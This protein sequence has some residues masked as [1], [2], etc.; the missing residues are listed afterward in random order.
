M[1]MAMRYGPEKIYISREEEQDLY[2][3]MKEGDELARDDLIIGHKYLVFTTANEYANYGSYEDLVQEGFIGLIRAVDKYDLNRS[4]LRTYSLPAIRQQ[5]LRY[6]NKSRHIIRLPEPQT[7][8]LLKL[9]RAKSAIEEKLGREATTHELLNDPTVIENHK[10]FQKSYRSKLTIKEYI[11]LLEFSTSPQSLNAPVFDDSATSFED[12][13]ED[14]RQRSEIDRIDLE[15][16]LNH[17]MNMLTD[18]E[19]FILESI[20]DGLTGREIGDELDLTSQSVFMIK[21][22]AIKKIRIAT[23]QNPELKEIIDDMGFKI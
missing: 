12:I 10:A 9:L 18:R 4:R 20:R 6:L 3:R 14:P 8:A 19:R 15:D 7:Y 17:V 5:M 1:N 22:N 13:L 11:G 2:D 21:K 16:L 23:K